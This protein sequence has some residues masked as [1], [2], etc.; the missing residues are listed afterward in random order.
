MTLPATFRNLSLR[1]KL[2][3]LVVTASMLTL[4]LASLS[5]FAFQVWSSRRLV[6]R[7][8]GSQGVIL[9][10]SSAAALRYLDATLGEEVLLTLLSNS[11]VQSAGLYY[12]DGRRLAAYGPRQDVP[13]SVPPGTRDGVRLR[14]SHA[15]LWQPVM[16]KDRRLGTLHLRFDH[17]TMERQTLEPFLLILGGTLL[18]AF[19]TSLGLAAALHPV[20]SD[21]V[22]R[23]AGTAKA[24]AERQDYSVRATVEGDDEIG[25][26]TAAFNHMLGQIQKQD[27]ALS[28]SQEKLEALVDSLAGIVWECAPDDFRF[29]FVSRQGSRLLGYPPEAWLAAADFWRD[30]LHPDDVGEATDRRRRLI[31]LRQPYQLE[32]RMMTADG[33]VVWIRESGDV[34]T[35]DSRPAVVRG[36][37]LDVTGQKL[38][39]AEVERLHSQLVEASRQA[40]MAEVATGVLH[41]VGNVLNSVNVS[42]DLI[43][44][45]LGESKV[46]SLPK[47]AGLLEENAADL[48]GFLTRDPRGRRLTEYL[49]ALSRHLG[50]ERLFVLREVTTLRKHID[51]IKEVVAMQQ[52][53]ARRCGVIESVS[54]LRLVEDALELNAGG[55][56]RH[57]VRVNREFDEVPDIAVEKHKVL[58]ILVNLI[59]N[60]ILAL[61][62]GNP[63]HKRLR[64]RSTRTDAGLVRIEVIDNGIGISPENLT[65]IFQHGFTT[66]KDGHGFGLHSG[67]LAARELGG[68][69]TAHSDGPGLGATFVLDLPSS[70]EPA[71]EAREEDGFPTLAVPRR[72]LGR[73][74]TASPPP[75]HN[76]YE[77]QPRCD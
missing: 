76:D 47:V 69:L 5:Q 2:F 40:G 26:L 66:R 15:E 32:Y 25:L 61:D 72:F 13:E 70:P 35:E 44:D 46:M 28:R 45:R 77:S 11:K 4:L 21:P 8:L 16:D 51:H 36:L 17:R 31:A 22:R 38:A 64:I 6:I 59:R 65:R 53:Y 43:L 9:A 27:A 63:P 54:P 71:R 1:R 67:A 74:A 12:P 19:L 39:A 58:Q 48:A 52:S 50:D 18:L 20:I 23:L 10:A 49:G 60:A 73:S 14:G 56:S 3:A 55:L 62:E 75:A 41:N 57:G 7:D 33:R 29:T 24:V 42:A 68:S 30:H 37:F 34:R